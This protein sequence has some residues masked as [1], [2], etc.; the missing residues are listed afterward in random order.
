MSRRGLVVWDFDHTLI[1][2]SGVD[3]GLSALAFAQ[4]TG[5]Y[6]RRQPSVLAGPPKS[7]NALKA[8]QQ[9]ED[10]PGAGSARANERTRLCPFC[11]TFRK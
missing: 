1:G 11:M 8:F 3:R 5:R 6:L 4:A 9:A 7:R 10:G 2:T